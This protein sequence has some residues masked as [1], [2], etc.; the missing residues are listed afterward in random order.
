MAIARFTHAEGVERP[1]AGGSDDIAQAQRRY[2]APSSQRDDRSPARVLGA[3]ALKEDAWSDLFLAWAPNKHLSV[4]LAWVDLGHI[5]PAVQP[6]R[7][8]GAYLSAQFAY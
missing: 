8:R 2:G 7:Q 4:T 3:G 6:R 1:E 5:A